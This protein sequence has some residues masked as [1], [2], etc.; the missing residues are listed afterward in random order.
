MQHHLVVKIKKEIGHIATLTWSVVRTVPIYSNAT[1]NCAL[2]FYQKLE[3]LMY[4]DPD[5]L[6]NKRSETMFRC[7]HQRKYLLGNYDSKDWLFD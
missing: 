1:K 3:I 2:C 6:L 7:P 4:S 5:E